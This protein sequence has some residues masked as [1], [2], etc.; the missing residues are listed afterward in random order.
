MRCVVTNW[1]YVELLCRRV[2]E[3]VM[4][5][6]FDPE[7]IVALAKGGWFAGRII[8]DILGIDELVSV[9]VEHY[10]GLDEV[11]VRVRQLPSEEDLKGRRVLIVDDI[12]NTGMSIRAARDRI[13]EMG[14][15]EVKTATLLLLSTSK[16]IPDYFGECLEEWVWVIFPWNFVEEM[17]SLI[18]KVME[19][20]KK[21]LW[22]EWDI[23][24]EIQRRFG[25]DPV[26][27][28]ISQPGRFSEVLRIME[29]RGILA[30]YKEGERE[31]WCFRKVYE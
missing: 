4:E 21:D 28:E 11:E 23:K 26:Q 30:R 2:S 29:R 6:Y 13:E 19:G 14:V 25:L 9:R 22:T 27:L 7:V 1:E 12:A 20:E 15:E 8:C 5:D 3:Q 31:Y 17:V 16:Y 18:R 10:S 24:R